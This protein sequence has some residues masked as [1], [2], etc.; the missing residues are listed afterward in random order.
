MKPK[1]M[2]VKV[3]TS[4]LTHSSGSLDLRSMER[5]VRVLSDL[6]GAGHEII[7]VTSGAI[8]VGVAHLGLPERPSSLRRKQA[9]AAVGQ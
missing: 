4:T 2:V 6:C 1:R 3:G 7:L 9:A 8:A 5:L